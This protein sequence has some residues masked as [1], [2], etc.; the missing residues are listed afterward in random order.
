MTARVRLGFKTDMDKI[1]NINIHRA[2][3]YV[4]ADVVS[5]VMGEFIR[6]GVYDTRGRGHLEEAVNASLIVTESIHFDVM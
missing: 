6:S 5:G 2:N 4:Q 3:E 1:V